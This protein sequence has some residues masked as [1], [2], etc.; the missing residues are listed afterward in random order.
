MIRRIPALILAGVFVAMPLAA[1]MAQD[2]ARSFRAENARVFQGSGDEAALTLPSQAAPPAVVA[3]FLR[4]EGFGEET[5]GSLVVES[6][7]TAARS[8]VTHLRFGQQVAGL[9][10]FGAYAKAAVNED[11]ELVHL[12]EALAPAG[13][14]VIPANASPRGAL[15]AA[16]EEVHPGLQTR[17]GAPRRDGNTDVF[18]GDDVFHRDPTVTRVA[19]AMQSGVLQEG[20]LVETWT[21]EDNLLH[22]VLVGGNGRVLDVQLRTNNDSYNVFPDHPVNSTQTVVGGPGAGNGESPVGWLDAGNHSSID[23]SGNNV[24][25]YLDRDNNNGADPGGSTVSNGDFVADANLSIEPTA[26][27]NQDVAVQNLFY[28]NNV[29]HDVL[30]G[31]GFV[32]ATG[33]FQEDNFG[34]GG[35]GSDSVNAEAQDG[36]GTSNANFATPSDGSNPRMQMYLWTQSTPPRDGDLDS[37]IIW[38]EYGHGLTWRMIGS[39]SGPMSGAIGE[40]MSDALAIVINNDDVVGEYSYNN[41]IGI[42]SERYSGYSRTYG[43]FSGGSVH[44][45]G[46]IYAAIVWDLW[47]RYQADLLT[48]DDLLGDLVGGMN[49]TPAGPAFEDMRDGILAQADS[50]RDCTVWEAFAAFGVGEG[51]KGSVKGGGPFGGGKVSVTESFQLPSECSGGPEPIAASFTDDCTGLECTFDGSGSTGSISGYDWDFDENGTTDASG[52]TVTHTFGGDGTYPVTLTVFGSGASDSATRNIAVSSGGTRTIYSASIDFRKKGPHLDATVTI[53]RAD[54]QTPV[55]DAMLDVSM[56]S[57]Q[58]CGFAGTSDG[59]TDSNGQRTFKSLHISTSLKYEFTVVDA[60]LAGHV[61]DPGQ[62]ESR[63]C[64][65]NGEVPCDSPTAAAGSAAASPGRS[66]AAPASG[67]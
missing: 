27:P 50:A 14:R 49:F 55:A 35:S 25:A 67:L 33:N 10:V 24:N 13:E 62:G 1:S 38:H 42:R 12:I 4:D 66:G 40:G 41:P 20:F 21:E 37:D 46:E 57:S 59:T 36:G 56:C 19:I 5:I 8:G 48:R 44:F 43:D 45:D 64:Y 53:L 18:P 16:L 58:G 11:G 23:I 2:Q 15:D 61:Y 31:H 9:H 3:N 60:V 63:S 34:S 6:E 29:I 65:D 28:F 54:D 51:A 52:V 39:M 26:G 30:Y 22:H 47:G 17:F 32:E 7:H